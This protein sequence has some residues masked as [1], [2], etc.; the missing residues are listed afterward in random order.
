METNNSAN[1][2]GIKFVSLAL[3]GVFLFPCLLAA[4]PPFRTD[5]PEP[6]EYHHWEFYCASQMTSGPDAISGTAPGVEI[7]YGIF[8][9][10]QAHV[11]IPLTLYR[12]R[13]GRFEYGPG[14][15][16]LGLKY[17]FVHESS[18]APQV[19]IFPAIEIP[20]GDAAKG[21]GTGNVQFFIP[22][23]LQKT[24]GSWTTYGGGGYLANAASDPV[25]SW[26]IG[27]EAQRDFSRALTLGGEIFGTVV[28]SQRADNELAFNIG[29][30]VNLTEDNH[31][32][33][34]AG[35]DIV[36]HTDFM[37]YA[38]YQLTIGPASPKP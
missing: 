21:L 25:N 37:F 1:Q 11:I 6:V 31:L 4:G 15:I 29:A 16:E 38:A 35:S 7:N 8:R 23:W 19:G 26:F 33:F 3:L 2:L 28:Q 20:T 17:R 24:W 36:G 13:A 14:D 27:W 32:L 5:D 12:P 18:F 22:L 30:I 10:A 34:S 9:E